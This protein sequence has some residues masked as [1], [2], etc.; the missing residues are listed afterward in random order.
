[1]QGDINSAPS[2]VRGGI[3]RSF[4]GAL[5]QLAQSLSNL[6]PL[7]TLQPVSTPE[8][9]IVEDGNL[10]V[11]AQVFINPFTA[12]ITSGRHSRS[13][14]RIFELGLDNGR[15]FEASELARIVGLGMITT[16]GYHAVAPYI[17]DDGTAVRGYMRDN[18]DISVDDNLLV[19]FGDS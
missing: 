14:D 11:F 3:A 17:R 13:A 7:D 12:S 1:V 6:G 9:S 10:A 16:P 5:D 8:S 15:L 19:R 2:I 18:P 4:T